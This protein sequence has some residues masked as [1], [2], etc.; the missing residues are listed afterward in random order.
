MTASVELE[1]R[2][3][4]AFELLGLEVTVLGQGA[5]RVAD[6]IARCGVGRWAIVF[7]AKIRTSGFSMGTEDRKFREYVERHGR[8]LE[9]EG[10]ARVY[11]AVVSSSFVE[12]DLE[13]AQ[14]IVRL[15][16]AKAMV[17][18][19]AGALRALVE[20]KLRTRQFEDAAA[21]ERVFGRP[22]CN[23]C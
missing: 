2:T 1:R 3:G 12:S 11:F 18:L 13:K 7:D 14:E 5:G 4:I 9:S 8:E 23:R 15:T 16:K 10:I 6:G 21:L 17:L 20:L 19:E 22:A